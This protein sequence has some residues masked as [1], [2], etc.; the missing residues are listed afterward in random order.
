MKQIAK[1]LSP[2][3]VVLNICNNLESPRKHKKEKIPR[4]PSSEQLYYSFWEVRLGHQYSLKAP[5]VMRIH[6]QGR[7][8]QASSI[9]L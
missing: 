7:E 4:L 2:N 3:L 1:T 8:L 9:R 6:S 5:Q